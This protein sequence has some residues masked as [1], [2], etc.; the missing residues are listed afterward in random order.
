MSRVINLR[1]IPDDLFR[2]FKKTCVDNDTDMTS[3]LKLLMETY[4]SKGKTGVNSTSSTIPGNTFASNKTR[5]DKQ[6]KHKEDKYG[7]VIN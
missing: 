7:K 5:A 3:A 2:Q 1:G 4:I 6:H